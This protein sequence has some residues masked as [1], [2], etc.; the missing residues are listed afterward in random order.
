MS[1]RNG[2]QLICYPNRIGQDLK[3]LKTVVD[4]H[5]SDAIC[6]LHILPFFCLLYTS[7]S[8]RDRG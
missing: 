4:T 2:I 1:L 3:D 8:P 5:L 6:G 7:P